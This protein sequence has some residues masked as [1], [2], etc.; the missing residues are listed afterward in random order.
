MNIA[1]HLPILQVVVPLISA[2][3]ATGT[4]VV[5]NP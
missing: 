1:A 3:I 2:P 5:P 4:V